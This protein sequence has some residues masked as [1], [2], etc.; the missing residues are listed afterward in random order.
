MPAKPPPPPPQRTSRSLSMSKPAPATVAAK[1]LSAL[2]QA[3]A[4]E[5]GEFEKLRGATVSKTAAG[6]SLSAATHLHLLSEAKQ[7]TQRALAHLR[8][9]G[10]AEAA[11]VAALK[12]DVADPPSSAGGGGTVAERT[13]R[14]NS[15][16]VLRTAPLR[17]CTPRHSPPP[18]PSDTFASWP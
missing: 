14:L 18:L 17:S 10:K 1:N 9:L 2:A 16:Y 6:V 3:R 8:K 5:L 12:R 15:P 4:R 13:A 11:L 7:A